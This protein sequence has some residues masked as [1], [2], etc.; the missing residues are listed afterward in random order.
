MPRRTESRSLAKNGKH[1]YVNAAFAR[2]M[3]HESPESMLGVNWQKIYDPRDIAV[4]SSS[5]FGNLSEPEGKWSGQINLRR[6]DGTMVPVE[7]AITS[8]ANGVTACIGHDISARKEA[9]KARADAE[10]KYRTLVEQVAAISYIAELGMNGQWHYI[11][12]QVE[13]ITGYSQDEWLANSRD[14]MRH[15]PQEDHAVIEAAEEASLAR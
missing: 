2:M 7:M 13:A 9:E 14:W 6:R 12:P 4:D 10:N 15:I 3:G 8:L 1:I 11:S 5:R